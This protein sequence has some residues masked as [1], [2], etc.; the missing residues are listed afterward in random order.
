[1]TNR[2]KHK[3]ESGIKKLQK[4]RIIS[5]RASERRIDDIE[6]YLKEKVKNDEIILL[7]LVEQFKEKNPEIVVSLSSI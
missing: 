5:K 7:G 3:I 2:K 1:M 6:N 4:N